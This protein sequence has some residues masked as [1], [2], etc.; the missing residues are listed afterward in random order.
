MRRSFAAA[1]IYAASVAMN[2]RTM[3]RVP[4]SSML[5]VHHTRTARPQRA[6]SRKATQPLGFVVAGA[7]Y[8]SIYRPC[9]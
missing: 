9:D 7:C 8:L 6:F 3:Q 2:R 1:A 4:T 5:I